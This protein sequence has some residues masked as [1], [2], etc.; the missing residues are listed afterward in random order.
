MLEYYICAENGL[1][2]LQESVNE[3]IKQGFK[4]QGGIFAMRYAVEET[5]EYTKHEWMWAQAMT[6]NPFGKFK[7]TR[8]INTP[9]P[10][11]E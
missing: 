11:Q 3:K 8:V 2:K 9:T 1:G 10:R 6:R 4:P 7:G 5:H